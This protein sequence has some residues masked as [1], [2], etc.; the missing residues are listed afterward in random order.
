VLDLVM[1]RV[2]GF[3]FLRRFRGAEHGRKT[4]G[5]VLTAKDLVQEERQLLQ[6]WPKAWWRK[7]KT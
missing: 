6:G 4:P 1:P 5:I 2:D 3:E 7:A